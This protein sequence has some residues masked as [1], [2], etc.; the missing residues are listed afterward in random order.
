MTCSFTYI[1]RVQLKHDLI[2]FVQQVLFLLL[3]EGSLL[4]IRA[5]QPCTLVGP[6][7]RRLVLDPLADY[8]SRTVYICHW[9]HK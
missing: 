8:S 4:T 1:D 7:V 9:I 3:T 2:N 6:P 5:Y